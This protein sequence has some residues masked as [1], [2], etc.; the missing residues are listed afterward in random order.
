M[1][2]TPHDDTVCPEHIG[3]I[4][5]DAGNTILGL[6]LLIAG[7]DHPRGCGEHSQVKECMPKEQGSSPRMRGTLGVGG[8]HIAGMGIIPA[9][10][11][12]T[13]C[14]HRS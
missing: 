13:T 2:G 9:D 12:N 8:G 4:P 6:G 1:R 7:A 10:A 5:A 3:I 14:G 11:G